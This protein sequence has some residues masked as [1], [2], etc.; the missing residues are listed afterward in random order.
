ML[1][2]STSLRPRWVA[3]TDRNRAIKI[4]G[5]NYELYL[6]NSTRGRLL[7]HQLIAGT[8]RL[9]NAIE[10]PLN[11]ADLNSMF[12]ARTAADILRVAKELRA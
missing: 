4:N 1:S 8:P 2:L 6:T 7:C 12:D 11:P 3:N 9:I 5:V 10:I